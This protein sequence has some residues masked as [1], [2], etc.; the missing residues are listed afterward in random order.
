MFT[1][2]RGCAGDIAALNLVAIHP[3]ND[4][5]VEFRLQVV[6]HTI[7]SLLGW[8]VE[9]CS[10]FRNFFGVVTGF[11]KDRQCWEIF[12]L[13]DRDVYEISV[14]EKLVKIKPSI[15][16]YIKA[17]RYLATEGNVRELVVAKLQ[18][19]PDD[20]HFRRVKMEALKDEDKSSDIDADSKSTASPS[21]RQRNNVPSGEL[22]AS[23]KLEEPVSA[24][25]DDANEDEDEDESDDE[26][27]EESS[28]SDEDDEEESETDDSSD[29]KSSSG[30]AKISKQRVDTKVYVMPSQDIRGFSVRLD[31]KGLS[32]IFKGL[33]SDYGSHPKLFYR[34]TDGDVLNI[35]S[36]NDFQY[37]FR[38]AKNSL[39][40]SSKNESNSSSS[41]QPLKLKLFAE[42][43]GILKSPASPSFA[44]PPLG[45]VDSPVNRLHALSINPGSTISSFT[46]PTMSDFSVSTGSVSLIRPFPE[47]LSS[48]AMSSPGLSQSMIGG[49][50]Q[51]SPSPATSSKPPPPRSS[52]GVIQGMSSSHTHQQQHLQNQ[53]LQSSQNNNALDF[54]IMWKRGEVL[55][56]GSFGQV[57]SGINLATGERMAVKEVVL[58][59]GKRQ[60]E[61]ARALQQE[62]RVLSALHHPNIIQYYGTEFAK[63]RLRIFLEL[64]TQGTLKDA[65]RE[66]GERIFCLYLNSLQC[67]I[68]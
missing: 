17:V 52:L 11:N 44:K 68:Y 54:N 2:K 61:Q 13:V 47:R 43:S 18:E 42:F 66:F 20:E 62:V 59:S 58:G 45:R 8:E 65:L 46:A 57:F 7:M 10:A 27:E 49:V 12:E 33:K 50:H 53:Q 28:S 24:E 21:R 40:T 26:E 60:L 34:D 1:Q 19:L 9:W 63:D 64:A 29:S 36:S 51:F 38:S 22:V 30:T 31:A 39:S 37:A 67:N 55:G 14:K 56:S 23:A 15:K 3:L 41:K 6:Y 35:K 5:L 4:N 32:K 25:H 16:E 48:S